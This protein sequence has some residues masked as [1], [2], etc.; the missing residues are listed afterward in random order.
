M[1]KN[2]KRKIYI[3]G[4]RSEMDKNREEQHRDHDRP[5]QGTQKKG[6]YIVRENKCE[7]SRQ[8]SARQ[9]SKS[10]FT[11]AVINQDGQQQGTRSYQQ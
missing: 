9:Q 4:E 11:T 8:K 6:Q 10:K 3:K 5:Y 7:I 1:K 2:K